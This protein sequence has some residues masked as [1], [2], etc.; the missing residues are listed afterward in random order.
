[1]LSTYVTWG[2]DK[3]AHPALALHLCLHLVLSW[4]Y[5]LSLFLAQH[6]DLGLHLKLIYDLVP[7]GKRGSLF[8]NS[9]G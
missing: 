1:M 3:K 7:H 9:V 5:Q 8:Q 2:S 6:S 4:E